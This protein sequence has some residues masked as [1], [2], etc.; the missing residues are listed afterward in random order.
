[1]N[2]CAHFDT[3]QAAYDWA[4]DKFSA[5]GFHISGHQPASRYWYLTTNGGHILLHLPKGRP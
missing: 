2:G 3:P 1:M 5:G 4:R